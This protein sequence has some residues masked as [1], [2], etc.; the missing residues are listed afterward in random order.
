MDNWEETRRQILA[1]VDAYSAKANEKM[2]AFL[3]A[4]GIEEGEFLVWL[5]EKLSLDD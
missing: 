2:E 5:R 4:H 3:K 1:N